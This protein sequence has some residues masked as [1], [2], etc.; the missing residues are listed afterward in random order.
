MDYNRHPDLRLP[1]T[2]GHM[3]GSEYPSGRITNKVY[4]M[5]DDEFRK[6]LP[7]MKEKRE[8]SSAVSSGSVLVVAGGYGDSRLLS[9][10][11]V[12]SGG[13]WTYGHTLPD[14]CSDMKSA[15]YGDRWILIGGVEQG[16]K[17]VLRLPTVPCIRN[18]TITMGDITR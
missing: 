10:V 1:P 11:E 5:I 17:N 12:Y 3:G 6:L 2:T 14:A 7:P 15:L 9:S 16:T 13:Q 8:S 4:T 18:R